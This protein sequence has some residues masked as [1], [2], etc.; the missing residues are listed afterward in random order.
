[1]SGQIVWGAKQVSPNTVEG[2]LK[3][4]L[5]L[6]S[7]ATSSGKSM[8]GQTKTLSPKMNTPFGNIQATVRGLRN[9]ADNSLNIDLEFYCNDD[10][11]T[12]LFPPPTDTTDYLAEYTNFL[13]RAKIIF[14]ARSP[15]RKPKTGVSI[16]SDTGLDSVRIRGT[17]AVAYYRP[18]TMM[19]TPYS[20]TAAYLKI[21]DVVFPL[22]TNHASTAER[23]IFQGIFKPD[24]KPQKELSYRRLM[25]EIVEFYEDYAEE[26]GLINAC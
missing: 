12:N 3:G 25:E 9:M 16:Q 2:L 14:D 7:C 26:Y 21:D 4:Q 1:M 10:I 15:I 11:M 18:A 24:Y 5:T 22:C 23:T 17:N 13:K 6:M 19:R 20:F 8:I